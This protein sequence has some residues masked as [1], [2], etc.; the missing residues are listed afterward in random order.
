MI[1]ILADHNLEGQAVLLWG[2]LVA[3]GWLE[4][5]PAALVLFADVGLPLESSDR[6]V[7]RMAQTR[8]MIL[9]T[10]NRSKRG[11][12]SLEQTIRE[13]NTPTSLPVLTIGNVA[14]LV[15]RTYREQCAARLVEIVLD[16]DNY[17]GTGRLF[18]P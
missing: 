16:I 6:V 18:I 9:L 3:E 11:E 17:I 5:C 13:E 2:T 8:G 10:D 4:L 7:W 14:R 15:E 1:T 12:D